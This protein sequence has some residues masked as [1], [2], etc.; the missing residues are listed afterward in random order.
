MKLGYVHGV[1]F[2]SLDANVVQVVQMCRAFTRSG[3]EVTLFIPRA[4]LFDSDDAALAAA[5]EF[6]AGKLPFRVEFVRRVRIFGRLEMLG[7]V[8]STLSAIR[9]AQPDLIYTRNPWTMLFLPRAG[10]PFV[11]EAHEERVHLRS[12]FLDRYLRRAIVRAA[13]R[14]SCMMVV[15]ISD[16]LRKIWEKFGVPSEKLIF[17]HD[18]VE[19]EMFDPEMSAKE[20]RAKLGLE[21]TRPLVVY[22]GAL[23]TDRGVDQMLEAARALPEMDICFVGGKEEEIAFWKKEAQCLGVA[24]VRFAGRV[25]HREIPLYLTAADV[26]LMMWTSRVPTIRGCS[27]MKMFEYM[28]ARRLIVGPAFPTIEEVLENG[29]DAI[30]FEP[31]NPAALI[32]AL[33]E[34]LSKRNDVGMPNAARSKVERE[35]TW[36]TRAEKILGEIEK[37]GM[38]PEMRNEK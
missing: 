19:L 17:A 35:Y 34:A 3:H 32:S 10:V 25:A 6:Y 13:R 22:T 20:A 21:S 29:K 15:A 7:S 12:R 31:D 11:F 8:R 37:R 5:R 23:K 38:K 16:A 36:Q 18:G 27:P 30:L 4:R 14:P 26:L 1:P 33:S 28:A 24:N 9:R 2:P